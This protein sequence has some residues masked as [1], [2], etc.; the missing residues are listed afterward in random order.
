MAM[1]APGP[2]S[3]GWPAGRRGRRGQPVGR[4]SLPVSRREG[5]GR[6]P[7]GVHPAHAAAAVTSRVEIG[8]L[9]AATS[10]RSPGMLAKVA[11]ALDF[12]SDGR[13]ILGLGCG[14]HEAEYGA[15]GYPFDHRVGRFEEVVVG[16]AAAAHGERVSVAGQ[17]IELDDAVMVPCPRAPDPDRDRRRGT[18][19]DV[20]SRLGWRTAG[21]AAGPAFPTRTSGA[22]WR[23]LEAACEAAAGPTGSRCSRA[24]MRRTR[25]TRIRTSRSTRGHRRG[26]RRLGRRG[27]RSRP[28]APLSRPPW[29][30]SRSRSRASAGSR[31]PSALDESGYCPLNIQRWPSRSS[32]R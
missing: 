22:S 2:K 30:R 8:P 31:A 20:A 13:L 3:G 32:A 18:A 16:G 23:T 5:R 6:D 17:W 10:F 29:R 12:V 4:R 28:G 19:D 14:W 7:G 9:V 15:F 26:A 21:S 27:H 11:T 1:A 24:S 25:S